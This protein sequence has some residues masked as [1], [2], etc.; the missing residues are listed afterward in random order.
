MRQLV[1]ATVGLAERE[2]EEVGGF[3]AEDAA[4]EVDGG[5]G[6]ALEVVVG[7]GQLVE[8]RGGGVRDG[9]AED[10]AVETRPV[11]GTEAHGAGLAGRV[12]RAAGEVDRGEGAAGL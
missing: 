6:E 9:G 8:A 7:D 10:D 4:E 2:V 3:F 5:V 11:T 12:D 1:P